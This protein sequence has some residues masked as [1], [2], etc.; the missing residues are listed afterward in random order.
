MHMDAIV[1]GWR[2][3]KNIFGTI[4]KNRCNIYENRF[5]RNCI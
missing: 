3:W 4:R 1:F 5:V 2:T